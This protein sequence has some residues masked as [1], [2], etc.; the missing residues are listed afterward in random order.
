MATTS[1]NESITK[2]V[3]LKI[4]SARK[5]IGAGEFVKAIDTCKVLICFFKIYNNNKS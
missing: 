4:K 5:Q 2:E 3:K 1:S